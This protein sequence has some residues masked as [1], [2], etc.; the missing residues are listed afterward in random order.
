MYSSQ[1]NRIIN[2]AMRRTAIILVALT[3]LSASAQEKDSL[4]LVYEHRLPFLSTASAPRRVTLLRS[5]VSESRED[6]LVRGTLFT[7]KSRHSRRVAIA[8]TFSQ[9]KLRYMTRGRE[10]VWYYFLP[11]DDR[12]REIEYKFNIDGTWSEDRS[13]PFNKEDRYG[14][15]IST[16]KTPHIPEGK[17]ITYRMKGKGI[18]EFR[19]F[20]PHARLIT[21][22]G[23]FNN[24]NP[25]N[26]ILARGE[27][28]IWRTTMRLPSGTYRYRY[29][30]DGRYSP[31]IYNRSSGSDDNGDLCS[32]LSVK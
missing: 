11:A 27:D 13:N 31:D 3:A 15:L 24:W 17:Q 8:G 29:I 1:I 2:K 12:A 6:K 30:V 20:N 5:Y 9:W 25:E 22:V 18:I 10:G 14:S 4:P 21:V 7:I 19:I 26:N 32:V 16:L 28:G 23:D